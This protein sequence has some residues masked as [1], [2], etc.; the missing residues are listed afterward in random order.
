MLLHVPA[1]MHQ[2]ERPEFISREPHL[3]LDKTEKH[4]E[5]LWQSEV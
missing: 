4:E 1:R 3:V 5:A 2:Q